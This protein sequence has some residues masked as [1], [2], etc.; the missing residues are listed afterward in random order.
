MPVKKITIYGGLIL[1]YNHKV[2]QEGTKA[3]EAGCHLFSA[4]GTWWKSLCTF[5]L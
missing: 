1:I 4:L 2:H 3:H 5:W